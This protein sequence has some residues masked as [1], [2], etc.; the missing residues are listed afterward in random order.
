[1]MALHIR[2]LFVP[3]NVSA[4]KDAAE[5][6]AYTYIMHM[7][8]NHSSWKVC[9]FLEFSGHYHLKIQPS[10]S[11]FLQYF[12]ILHLKSLFLLLPQNKLPCLALFSFH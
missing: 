4:T 10:L 1:M 9:I 5:R 3:V 7:A 8:H 6:S 2:L 11:Y 12:I